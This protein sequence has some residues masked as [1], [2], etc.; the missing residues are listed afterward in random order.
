[1]SD[2]EWRKDQFYNND[3][4]LLHFT[5]YDTSYGKTSG[6]TLLHKHTPIKH[7]VTLNFQ[8]SQLLNGNGISKQT[9][10]QFIIIQSF[11]NSRHTTMPKSKIKRA[12]SENSDDGE[13]PTTDRAFVTS[14]KQNR[15]D[16]R[17]GS[18]TEKRHEKIP[19]G[20][21]EQLKFN[22]FN[23]RFKLVLS[24]SQLKAYGLTK[25]SKMFADPKINLVGDTRIYSPIGNEDTTGK[26][27]RLADIRTWFNRATMRQRLLA[28]GVPPSTIMAE[29]YE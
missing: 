5:T 25:G 11:T 15:P 22:S 13:I 6:N 28:D 26:K 16:S 3:H 23:G 29:Q 4:L 1:M 27:R 18:T 14:A 19:E 8:N 24:T 10:C 9:S 17:N 21:T 20:L 2:N 7:L 12:R